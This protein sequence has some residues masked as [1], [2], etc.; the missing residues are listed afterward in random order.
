MYLRN[1]DA[2]IPFPELSCHIFKWVKLPRGLLI[3][4]IKNFLIYS[5]S[6]VF[7]PSPLPAVTDRN[8][9]LQLLA[10]QTLSVVIY[11]VLNINQKF[12]KKIQVT[13]VRQVT[14]TGTGQNHN[15]NSIGNPTFY[16]NSTFFTVK[17]T[18]NFP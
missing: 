4:E 9:M 8:R 11:D 13:L 16:E 1:H 18:L 10:L 7:V 3:F 17:F 6:Y 5:L 14:V 2:L 12:K 15:F